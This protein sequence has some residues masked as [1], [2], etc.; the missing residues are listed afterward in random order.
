MK[1]GVLAIY[2]RDTGYACRLMEYLN[3]KADFILESRV[4]TNALNLSDYLEK[5]AVE[6]LLLGEDISPEEFFKEK[7]KH[8]VRLS[9]QGFVVENSE[10][11]VLY[12]YQPM[13]GLVGE[14]SGCYGNLA[15]TAATVAE[16]RKNKKLIGIFSPFGGSG[17]TLFA[18]ALGQALCGRTAL[19]GRHEEAQKERE[20]QRVLY[21]GMELVSSFR[22]AEN[23]GGNLSELLYWIR[24]RKEGCLRGASGMAEKCGALEC[25]FAPDYYEDL[26]SL[27]KED[28]DFFLKELYKLSSYDTILFDVGCWNASMY[29]LLEQLDEVYMPDFLKRNFLRK[30][31]SLERSMQLIGRG[32]LFKKLQRVELPFDEQIYQGNYDLDKLEKT[33]MGQFVCRLINKN[34]M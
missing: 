18:L 20:T 10:Y 5:N 3:Q 22:E 34:S 26:I 28:M 32:E 21:I 13:E 29:F 24:E 33:K 17:K 31:E 15:V 30:E 25:I 8:I 11:P 12:K 14:L 23:V 4:F 16:E 19:Y 6:I 27:T 7:A 9:E 2:D 1:Q